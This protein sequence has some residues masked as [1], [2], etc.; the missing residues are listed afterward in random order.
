MLSDRMSVQIFVL[1]YVE[2][3][4]DRDETGMAFKCEDNN[5]NNN[6]IPPT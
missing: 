3:V 1:R 6:N 2:G 4:L 5:N